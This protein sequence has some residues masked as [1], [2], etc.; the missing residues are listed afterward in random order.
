MHWSFEAPT[1]PDPGQVGGFDKGPDQI[2]RKPSTPG[3]NLEIEFP[4]PWEKIGKGLEK[5]TKQTK[6]SKTKRNRSH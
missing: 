2:I 3:E 1:P 6:Q 5:K 4:S